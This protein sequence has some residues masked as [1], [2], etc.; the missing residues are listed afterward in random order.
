[1]TGTL[2]AIAFVGAFVLLM[3]MEKGERARR[4]QSTG[5][6]ILF[7]LGMVGVAAMMFGL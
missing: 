2:T 4:W 7:T 3:S 1:M 6:A 5:F